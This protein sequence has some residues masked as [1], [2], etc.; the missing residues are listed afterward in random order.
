VVAIAISGTNDLKT[1]I[2]SSLIAVLLGVSNSV[3]EIVGELP[4]YQR[5]RLVNLKIPSYVFSKFTV[6]SGISF[7]QCFLWV[8]VMVITQKLSGSDF[9]SLLIILYL[10]WLSGITVGLFFS[11]L[12]NSVEKALTALPLIV[13]LQLVLSGGIIPLCEVQTIAGATSGLG[14]ALNVPAALMP[15]RWTMDALA[16]DVSINDPGAS[17]SLSHQICMGSSHGL[18]V[19]LGILMLL[20][21]T[22][23]YLL[24]TMWALKRKDVL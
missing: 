24:L 21:F 1:L 18:H 9:F 14:A 23:L 19:F 5:E 2:F 17:M 16:N 3:R 8:V 13:A 22:G 12:V 7:I 11:A 20:I 6:L 10:T 15:M 4:I